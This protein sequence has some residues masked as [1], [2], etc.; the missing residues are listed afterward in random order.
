MESKVILNRSVVVRM[1]AR[2]LYTAIL[3]DNDEIFDAPV[4]PST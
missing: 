3:L 1:L 4:L 2:R